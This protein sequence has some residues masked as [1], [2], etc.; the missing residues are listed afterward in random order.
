MLRKNDYI[1]I[2]LIA[3]FVGVISISQ[4]Y[5][6]KKTTRVSQ[7][8]NNDVMALEIEKIAKTNA[9][10]KIQINNLSKEYDDYTSLAN[11]KNELFSKFQAESKM[12]DEIN[13][14]L[15][16]S[17]QG[18][19]ITISGNLNTAQ[20]VDTINA[21][22]NIGAEIISINGNRLVPFEGIKAENF[23]SPYQ[24]SALGNSAVLES[25]LTRKGGIVEQISG[26]GIE[27]KVEKVEKLQIPAGNYHLFKFA[28]VVE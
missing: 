6:V 24:I 27:I 22:R 19:T 25:A 2:A 1:I 11:N 17:G 3:F 13:G 23:S 8:E 28:N 7:P 20:L 26:H 9:G 5:S 14:V 4:Y 10:L 15:P 16:M 18:I 12:L 21:L